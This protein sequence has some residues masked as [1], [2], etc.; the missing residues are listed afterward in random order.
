MSDSF[1][2]LAHPWIWSFAACATAAA[3]E[4]ICA[5]TG[6]KQRFA[7]LSF[8]TPSLPLWAWSLVG[9][10]YYAIHLVVLHSLLS[11]RPLQPFTTEALALVGIV[12]TINAAW[13]Y[14]FFRRK[15]LR[16]SFFLS[17]PYALLAVTLGAVLWVAARDAALLYFVY[18]VYLPY[19]TWWGYAVWRRSVKDHHDA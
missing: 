3:R 4:G 16:S 11:S 1:L 7:E 18:L 9:V 14:L 6:V 5:G 13:N 2:P 15:D 12:L 8:P 19:G 10:G 17:V